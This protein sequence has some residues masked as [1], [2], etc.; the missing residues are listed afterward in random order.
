[1]AGGA[2]SQLFTPASTPVCCT[3]AQEELLFCPDLYCDRTAPGGTPATCSEC[4][5]WSCPDHAPECCG[6]EGA[7]QRVRYEMRDAQIPLT[8]TTPQALLT[9]LGRLDTASLLVF[10]ASDN[11]AD[12]IDVFRASERLHNRWVRLRRT[13]FSRMRSGPVLGA[14]ALMSGAHV[15]CSV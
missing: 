4:H 3:Y 10:V 6:G 15:S 12:V 9:E 5:E 7:I 1:V 8:A 2:A 11:Y 13:L 14:A